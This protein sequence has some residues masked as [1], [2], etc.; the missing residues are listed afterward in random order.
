MPPAHPHARLRLCILM[1]LPA[2]RS[3]APILPLRSLSDIF[4]KA[5]PP[6][7]RGHARPSSLYAAN[8]RT[9]AYMRRSACF[10]LSHCLHIIIVAMQISVSGFRAITVVCDCSVLRGASSFTPRAREAVLATVLDGCV[11]R[12]ANLKSSQVPDHERMTAVLL[13]LLRR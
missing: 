11:P 1:L 8:G 4:A 2:S 5:N 13:S 9:C 10:P 6:P 7:A 12:S 3:S